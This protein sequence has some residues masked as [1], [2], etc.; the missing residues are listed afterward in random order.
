MLGWIRAFDSL[1]FKGDLEGDRGA[2]DIVEADVVAY[3]SDLVGLDDA[4]GYRD[5]GL[6]FREGFFQLFEG[7]FI[8]GGV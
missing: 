1:D 4:I 7:G 5:L 8:G 2:E 3:F 6:R